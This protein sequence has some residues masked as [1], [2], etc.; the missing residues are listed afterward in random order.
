MAHHYLTSVL[1]WQSVGLLPVQ[2]A[3]AESK[4][5]A[6]MSGSDKHSE[7][8]R[9]HRGLRESRV[10]VLLGLRLG[11]P[12]GPEQTCCAELVSAPRIASVRQPHSY[13]SC[14]CR[15][16]FCPVNPSPVWALLFGPRHRYLSPAAT[17]ATPALSA[18]N[19][20]LLLVSGSSL[21]E[22]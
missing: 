2:W 17:P 11:V 5:N 3:A 22:H 8:T 16:C 7:E 10:G 13:V 18:L 6:A 1:H 14:T 4:I 21:L 12:H 15:C 9:A 20:A 19:P